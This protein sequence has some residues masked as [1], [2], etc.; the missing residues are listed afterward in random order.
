[1]LKAILALAKALDLEVVAE[2]VET[3]FEHDLVLQLGCDYGQGYFY[4]KPEPSLV[5]LEQAWPH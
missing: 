4:G 2:G 3:Q 1:M 5:Q